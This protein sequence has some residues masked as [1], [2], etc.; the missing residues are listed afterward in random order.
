MSVVDPTL[1]WAVNVHGLEPE[2]FLD[3][4]MVLDQYGAIFF[5]GAIAVEIPTRSDGLFVEGTEE[6]LFDV[7]WDGHVIL[8]RVEA[9]ENDIE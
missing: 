5:I 6:G 8:D 9:T 7:V 1:K 2:Q 3:D 4:N